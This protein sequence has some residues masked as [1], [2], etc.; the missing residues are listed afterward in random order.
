[1]NVMRSHRKPLGLTV[2]DIIALAGG[3]RQISEESRRLNSEDPTCKVVAQK[4]VYNWQNTGIP[5]WYWELITKMTGRVV[6][7]NDIYDANRKLR[8]EIRT[9]LIVKE[10]MSKSEKKKK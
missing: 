3:P 6:S 2:P 8:K 9:G 1:M 5:E 10:S 7:I 4:S